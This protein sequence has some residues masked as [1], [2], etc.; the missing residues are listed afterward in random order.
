MTNSVSD[1]VREALRAGWSSPRYVAKAELD[2]AG[3]SSA[4]SARVL[5]AALAER[6]QLVWSA[7]ISE[8]KVDAAAYDELANE[9]NSRFGEGL[10]WLT[11]DREGLGLRA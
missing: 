10:V 7:S 11:S 1:E 8:Y 4:T 2:A 3:D 5:A 9:I 6:A